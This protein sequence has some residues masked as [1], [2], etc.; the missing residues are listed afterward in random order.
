MVFGELVAPGLTLPLAKRSPTSSRALCVVLSLFFH[1][2]LWPT[3]IVVGLGAN[4]WLPRSPTIEMVTSAATVGADGLE[5]PHAAAP[6]A[7][8]PAIPASVIL[9]RETNISDLRQ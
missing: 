5:L 2:T 6:S 8:T 7:S 1:A 9:E 3:R 4:D